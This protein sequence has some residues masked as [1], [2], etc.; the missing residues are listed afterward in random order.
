[1]KR[2]MYMLLLGIMMLS[3]TI[4]SFANTRVSVEFAQCTDGD[5][6]HFII[7]GKD[8]TVRFL[9]VD[10]PEYTKEKEPY[11][12]EASEFTCQMLQNAKV[13]ELEYDDGSDKRD[14]YGRDLAWVFVD[15]ELLQ[16]KLVAQGLAEVAYIYG[17]YAYTEELYRA[18]ETAQKQKLHIWSEDEKE[19][20]DWITLL[21]IG[22]GMAVIVF[23]YLGN[24]KDK[25]RKINK[26]KKVMRQMAER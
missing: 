25:K 23:L 10:T 9:A 7:A 22:I 19:P 18:Q 24:G 4:S 2:W 13:I 14:K 12:K 3:C 8:T 6:A 17:E 21:T 15:G 20:Y 11:G 1:M 16:Q 26:V 5:T